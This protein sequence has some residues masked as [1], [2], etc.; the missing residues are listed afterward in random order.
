MQPLN[1]INNNGK[2]KKLGCLRSIQ[3]KLTKSL[4][5]ALNYVKQRVY[6]IKYFLTS[7]LYFKK[8]KIN[9]YQRY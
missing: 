1:I 3:R 7:A 6:F 2:K 8:Y 4:L 9:P 5:I